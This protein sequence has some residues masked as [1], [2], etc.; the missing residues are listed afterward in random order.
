MKKEERI[1]ALRLRL[2]S[3]ESGPFR[4]D[5]EWLLSLVDGTTSHGVSLDDRRRV[6][7]LW[8]KLFKRSLCKFRA[9]DRRD[10][11]ITT[12]VKEHGMAAIE[13]CL[14]GY[15]SDPWRHEQPQRHELVTLL[16]SDG[17]VESGLEMN[18]RA[19]DDS[20]QRGSW[21]NKQGIANATVGYG[22]KDRGKDNEPGPNDGDGLHGDSP[23]RWGVQWGGARVP[24]DV[25]F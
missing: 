3:G 11:K 9:G 13:D 20:N 23:N 16:R 6:F 15:A 4:E 10:K 2:S 8:Q 12:R 14:N 1:A 25:P 17:S 22:D 21:P 18:R 7:L 5:A 19:R 24:E